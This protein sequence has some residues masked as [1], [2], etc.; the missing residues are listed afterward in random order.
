MPLKL[1]KRPK[2]PY[3]VMRG[4]VRG[5]RVEESTGTAA[6]R[7]AEE[8]RAKR[9][10]EL[11]SES[12]YGKIA[13]VT[14]AEAVLSLVQERGSSRFLRPLLEH[15]GTTPLKHIGQEAIDKAALKLY[16]KG[17][18]ATR[19]RQVYTPASA[20]LQHAARKGWCPRPVLARPKAARAV[21]ERIESWEGF[22]NRL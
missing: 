20:V 8:I 14:F 22:P 7:A 19:N 9:E 17:S 1:V 4:T 6:R 3:W 21:S 12:V 13:T 16:P 10:A 5:I 11:L 15:F 2:S 18:D